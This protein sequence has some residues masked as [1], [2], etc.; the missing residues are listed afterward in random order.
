MVLAN[1]KYSM[2]HMLVCRYFGQRCHGNIVRIFIRGEL[3]IQRK[4]KVRNF[5]GNFSG[6][7]YDSMK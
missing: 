7:L 5:C 2:L 6:R 1:T 4:E 3:K